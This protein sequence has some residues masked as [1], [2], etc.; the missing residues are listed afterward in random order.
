MKVYLIIQNDIITGYS[1]NYLENIPEI[2]IENPTTIRLGIDKYVNGK[3]I[4][5]EAAYQKQVQRDTAIGRIEEL[6]NLLLNTDHKV[7][8]YM[9]GLIT[10]EEYNEVKAQR[11]AWRAEIHELEATL[12]AE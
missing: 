4:K 8:K 7:V 1:Y 9:E 2:E 5:D 3:I 12:S 6:K 11:Q 10:E